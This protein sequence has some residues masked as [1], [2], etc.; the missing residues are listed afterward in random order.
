MLATLSSQVSVAQW[1]QK[2]L[3]GEVAEWSRQQ[4][5]NTDPSGF[6]HSPMPAIVMQVGG[7]YPRQVGSSHNE[8]EVG[9]SRGFLKA[10]PPCLQILAENIQVTSLISDSLHRRVQDRALSELGVFLRRFAKQG[11][12]H[13]PWQ[14]KGSE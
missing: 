11:P 1:L 5:P 9:R 6:Y 13:N 2:A 10:A 8:R 3:D 14:P 7:K 12:I 4:E